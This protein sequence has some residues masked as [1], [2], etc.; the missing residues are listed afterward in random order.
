MSEVDSQVVEVGPVLRRRAEPPLHAGPVEVAPGLEQPPQVGLLRAVGPA[1]LVGG[2]ALPMALVN[3]VFA[4]F[5]LR[6]EWADDGLSLAGPAGGVRAALALLVAT[7]VRRAADGT[8]GRLRA[9]AAPECRWVF[10]DDS[11]NGAGRWCSMSSCGNRQKT[12]RY[13]AKRTGEPSG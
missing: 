3:A 6:A 1:R 8:W 13:R 2:D 5:P 10:Y 9:C 7:A 4:E 11:R 12:A